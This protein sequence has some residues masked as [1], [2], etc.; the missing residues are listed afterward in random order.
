MNE[1]GKIIKQIENE[2]QYEWMVLIMSENLKIESH[3]ECEL[4]R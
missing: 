1:N 2:N 3:I 4:L